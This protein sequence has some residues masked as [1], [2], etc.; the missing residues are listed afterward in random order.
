MQTKLALSLM[1]VLAALAAAGQSADRTPARGFSLDAMDRSVD[2]CVDFYQY[3]CGGWRA[4]NPIPADRSAWGRGSELQERNYEVLRDILEK[5]AARKTGA[6]KVEQEVGTFWAACMDEKVS[7]ARGFEPIAPELKRIADLKSKAEIPGLLAHLH[8]TGVNALFRTDSEQDFKDATEVIAVTDQRGLSLPDRD[9]YLKDDPKFVENRKQYLAH[10]EKMFGMLGEPAEKAAADAKVVMEI[11]TKLA[12]A[13]MDRVRRREPAN[14]Y[15]R[16][17]VA[18]LAALSPSF[19][20]NAYLK[21]A[22]VPPIESLN[23]RVPDFVKGM[24]GVLASRSLDDLKTYLRWQVTRANAPLLSSAFVEENFDFFGRKLTG[25][26]ENRPRWKRCVERTDDA[27]GEALGQLY[28][29]ATFGAEGKERMLKMVRALEAALERDIRELPWMTEATKEK[30]LE[31]LHAIANKIGYPEKYRDYSS[32]RLVSDDLVGNVARSNRFEFARQLNKIGK[33]VDPK[34]WFMTPPTVNA[35]YDPQQNN[36]NFPAGILQPP[37]FDRS[38]DDAVNF[39]GI[40]AVIGHELTHGFDD[41]GRKFDPKGNLKDWWTED[42]AREFEQR[43]SCVADQYSEYSPI[44]DVKLNGKL[45]LGE[46]TADNGG[47]RIAYMA[48]MDTIA[49][50]SAP[51]IEGFT[52]EQRFFLGWGQVWCQNITDQR[53][54]M[55][56]TIDPHSPGRFRVI[57]VVSNMP[58]FQKAFSCKKGQPM[59]R[60][61]ACRVW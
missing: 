61:N 14:I 18:E 40:G 6:S 16:M 25:A 13:S 56:A 60:E 50:K 44:A 41:E 55:L 54:K 20:W 49:G 28:V 24:E 36:I 10:L 33:P 58:E 59:V 22:G 4:K 19:D 35:Y 29:D 1:I 9:Y 2:P 15:H 26:K 23:V 8:Q 30:A 45:T 46:N 57:G 32:I 12:E 27:L 17:K 47:L 7:E 5:A 37:F 38:M 3:S 48:L 51:S 21:A 39:G 31:K 52:P 43:A 53:T 11:E 34:E 42:D